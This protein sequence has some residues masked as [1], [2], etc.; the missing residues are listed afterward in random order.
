M[1]RQGDAFG[2]WLQID[3]EPSW[4]GLDAM[5]LVFASIKLGPAF[6]K[7]VSDPSLDSYSMTALTLL[8]VAYAFVKLWP[9]LNGHNRSKASDPEKVLG[10]ESAATADLLLGPACAV[11]AAMTCFVVIPCLAGGLFSG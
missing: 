4:P 3:I 1:K 6:G 10:A 5:F 11:L 2:S 8:A 9:K 7:A